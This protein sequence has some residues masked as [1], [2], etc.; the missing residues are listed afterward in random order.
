MKGKLV[1][2]LALLLAAMLLFSL[3][4]AEG[5]SYDAG[6]STLTVVCGQCAP[7]GEY[8][9][10]FLKKGASPSA[11]TPQN[12]LFI[13]Q[14]TAGDDG[15]I[16]AAFVAP[17]FAESAVYV[18][19]EFTSGTASPRKLGN[20]APVQVEEHPFSAPAALSVIEEEAFA[21]SAFTHVYLGEQVEEIGARAFANCG[22]LVYIYIPEATGVIAADA[23][24]GCGS[25]VIGCRAGSAA[26][27]FAL[28]NGFAY[29][30]VS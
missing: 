8:A 15:T 20:Y 21:G 11:L 19:G 6:S 13:D 26:H 16:R 12:V 3:A 1:T 5:V 28:A 4:L 2:M 30:F 10:L 18:G 17:T 23:F 25:V 22:S 24:E 9:L 7:G 29:R 14:L 27:D